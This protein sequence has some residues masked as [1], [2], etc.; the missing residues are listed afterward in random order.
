M[1]LVADT[2]PRYL[3]DTA[4]CPA[5]GHWLTFGTDPLTGLVWQSCPCQGRQLIPRILAAPSTHPDLYQRNRGKVEK[6]CQN[7]DCGKAFRGLPNARYCGMTCGGLMAN[8]KRWR[9]G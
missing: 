5:C 6:V 9:R 8:R 3:A 4:K 1:R 7:P 2:S